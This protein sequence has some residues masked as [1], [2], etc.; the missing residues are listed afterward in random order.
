LA[1]MNRPDPYINQQL[2]QPPYSLPLQ[3]QPPQMPYDQDK[4]AAPAPLPPNPR[5]NNVNTQIHYN[6]YMIRFPFVTWS[7][8]VCCFFR[9]DKTEEPIRTINKK[10]SLT[11]SALSTISR[12]ISLKTTDTKNTLITCNRFI[13]R[14]IWILLWQNNDQTHVLFVFFYEEKHARRAQTKYKERRRL[15]W[16]LRHA[17]IKRDGVRSGIETLTIV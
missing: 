12:R 11:S 1:N 5:R 3:P 15:N 7:Y 13:N 6:Y 8:F 4:F 16:I 14:I 10:T 17:S 9:A 2:Q